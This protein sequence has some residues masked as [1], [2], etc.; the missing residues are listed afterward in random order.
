[1]FL[2]SLDIRN[3]DIKCGDAGNAVGEVVRTW[4]TLLVAGKVVLVGM[5]GAIWKMENCV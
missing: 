1:M 5:G 2:E 3:E 4:V